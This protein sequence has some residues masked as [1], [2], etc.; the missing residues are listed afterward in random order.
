MRGH[1]Y[2]KDNVWQRYI[3]ITEL[4]GDQLQ[5]KYI[6]CR[7]SF[8]DDL[9]KVLG[10]SADFV[11]P[12]DPCK[13]LLVFPTEY[14]KN[15]ILKL[16]TASEAEEDFTIEFQD[17]SDTDFVQS[18]VHVMLHIRNDLKVT[19]C[20]QSWNGI[21]EENVRSVI[22]DSLFLMLRLLFEGDTVLDEEETSGE[23]KVRNWIYSIAQDLVYGVSGGKKMTPKHIGLGMTIH[24]V[25]RSKHLIDLEKLPWRNTRNIT[26]FI[27]QQTSMLAISHSMLLII[28]TSWRKL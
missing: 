25:T 11:C 16:S 13:S 26:T 22:P 23:R 6:S 15:A 24:Q 28:L 21:N 9:A 27:F 4:F 3:D 1:V 18:L 20:H 12:L 19:K 10:K 14:F 17:D 8:K 5:Q 2:S 7:A